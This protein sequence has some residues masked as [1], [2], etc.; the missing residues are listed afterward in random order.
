MFKTRRGTVIF[1][2]EGCCFRTGVDECTGFSLCLVGSG[3]R[4]EKSGTAPTLL[5][6]YDISLLNKS[7]AVELRFGPLQ[8]RQCQLTF[9]SESLSTS[10]VLLLMFWHDEWY[11][12]SQV[13]QTTPLCS[14][15]TGWSQVP[16]R[17]S[18]QFSSITWLLKRAVSKETVRMHIHDA[19]S[20]KKTD[21]GWKLSFLSYFSIHFISIFPIFPTFSF[22]NHHQRPVTLFTDKNRQAPTRAVKNR[23]EPTR[24]IFMHFLIKILL[25][26]PYLCVI[27]PN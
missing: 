21:A 25:T 17:Y 23:Q 22:L 6:Q 9:S 12:W 3:F 14:Q 4:V 8:I 26:R 24:G 5:E 27:Y 19:F 20:S 18:L 1:F 15:V 16:Q 7:C 13:L 10:Y 2:C 11:H